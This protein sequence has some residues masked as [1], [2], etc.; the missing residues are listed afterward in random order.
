MFGLV[1]SGLVWFGLFWFVVVWFGL[2]WFARLEQLR[3]S[4]HLQTKFGLKVKSHD[5]LFVKNVNKKTNHPREKYYIYRLFD[6]RFFIV[7]ND[8]SKI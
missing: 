3:F 1:W 6:F 7:N 4:I 5:H 8:K 2:V